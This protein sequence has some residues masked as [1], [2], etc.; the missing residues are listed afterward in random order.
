M[1]E[2][3]LI[4]ITARKQTEQAM[5]SAV[6]AADAASLAKSEFL[7]NMSHEIRTPMNGI[8][9]MTELALGTN[10]TDEQRDYL[11]TVRAS[12]DSLLQIINDILD[13][14]KIEARKLDIGRSHRRHRL[15]V[16]VHPGGH[17]PLTR[18]TRAREGA[19]AGLPCFARRAVHARRRSGTPAADRHESHR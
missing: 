7:A 14:S 16:G 9:G 3:T 12:A 10:L 8:V 6:E 2:G 5:R 15:R 11:E 18:A 17:A 19:R 4:D 1:I 13:F